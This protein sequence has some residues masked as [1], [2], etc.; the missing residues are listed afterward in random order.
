MFAPFPRKICLTA[1]R[2][3]RCPSGARPELGDPDREPR[4]QRTGDLIGISQDALGP[5]GVRALTLALEHGELPQQRVDDPVL[6]DAV[7]QVILPLLLV[8]A[9]LAAR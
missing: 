4:Q 1:G 9:F 6:P 5:A 7:I 8:V 2:F 3:R